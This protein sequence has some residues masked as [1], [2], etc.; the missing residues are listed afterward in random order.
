MRFSSE[1]RTKDT[2][3]GSDE[4]HRER[5]G[6]TGV[7]HQFRQRKIERERERGVTGGESR[8]VA[9]GKEPVSEQFDCV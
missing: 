3:R 5:F 6:V 9:L 8:P 7:G 2:E 1:V 4:G